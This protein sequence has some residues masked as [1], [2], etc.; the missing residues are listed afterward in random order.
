MYI[1][2]ETSKAHVFFNFVA[3]SPVLVLVKYK[4]TVVM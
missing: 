4:L 3:S 1:T 2:N